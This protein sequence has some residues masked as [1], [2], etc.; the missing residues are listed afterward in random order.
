MSSWKRKFCWKPFKFKGCNYW[1][2]TIEYKTNK[3]GEISKVRI[4]STDVH[5]SI[6]P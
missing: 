5:M 3:K 2:T 4:P 6:H 1:L